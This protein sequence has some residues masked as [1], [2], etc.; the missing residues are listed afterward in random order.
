MP[1]IFL[2][3]DVEEIVTELSAR[4]ADESDYEE[5]LV[6]KF[7]KLINYMDNLEK[8]KLISD[9][10]TKDYIKYKEKEYE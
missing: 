8:K 3:P 6:P 4:L 7:V 1:N 10:F 9:G 2:N 5:N